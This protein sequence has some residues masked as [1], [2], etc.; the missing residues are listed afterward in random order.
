MTLLVCLAQTF[1][2]NS[3][4]L[5]RLVVSKEG[6]ADLRGEDGLFLFFTMIT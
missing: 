6:V 5:L 2:V 4:P 1:E 3:C